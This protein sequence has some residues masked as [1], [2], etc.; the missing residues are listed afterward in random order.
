MIVKI[1]RSRDLGTLEKAFEPS[2]GFSH[3]ACLIILYKYFSSISIF[4]SE[5]KPTFL[6]R[7]GFGKS[8]E[9]FFRLFNCKKKLN[10]NSKRNSIF[11]RFSVYKCRL[12]DLRF[13]TYKLVLERKEH[14]R[15][16]IYFLALGIKQGIWG[17][18]D[19]R[20]SEAA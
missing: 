13:K 4:I 8:I 12:N 11:F 16:Y 1:S 2:S 5:L 7:F 6:G 19:N 9:F 20:G 3:A 10:T 15:S 18:K 14:K 17:R